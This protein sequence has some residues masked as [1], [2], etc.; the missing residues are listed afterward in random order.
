LKTFA[1]EAEDQALR[2][3]RIIFDHKDAFRR[4][5]YLSIGQAGPA[6]P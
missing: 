3:G 6:V 4:H 5:L 2:N 1:L